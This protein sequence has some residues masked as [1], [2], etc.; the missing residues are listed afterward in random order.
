MTKEIEIS[1]LGEEV[2]DDDTFEMPHSIV[3]PKEI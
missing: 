2:N 3:R 1:D